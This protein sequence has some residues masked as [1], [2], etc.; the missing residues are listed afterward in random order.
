MDLV[1][2]VTDAPPSPEAVLDT[3]GC[4]EFTYFEMGNAGRRVVSIVMARVCCGFPHW[5]CVLDKP[6]VG[7][8]FG[9]KI[10]SG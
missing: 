6:F 2:P 8:L 1:S 5:N 4:L 7:L 3:R 9:L 10:V